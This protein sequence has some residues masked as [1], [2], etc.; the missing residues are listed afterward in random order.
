MNEILAVYATWSGA[1][2]PG[3]ALRGAEAEPK[4]LG[5]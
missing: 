1:E 3:E 5:K 4:V 2:A